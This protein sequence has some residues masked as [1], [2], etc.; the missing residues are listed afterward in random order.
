MRVSG[1]T[2]ASPSCVVGDSHVTVDEPDYPVPI[3]IRPM[4]RG[5]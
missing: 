2:R 5:G 1:I 3:P 4:A